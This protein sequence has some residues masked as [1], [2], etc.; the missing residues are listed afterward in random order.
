MLNSRC[1]GNSDRKYQN[2]VT[3][4]SEIYDRIGSHTIDTQ[5]N[6][7]SRGKVQNAVTNS[8][9]SNV[10]LSGGWGI[11]TYISSCYWEFEFYLKQRLIYS[12][13][14]LHTWFH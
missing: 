3:N 13:S 9:E 1:V 8:R 5:S 10:T 6:E 11:W 4:S 14:L 2:V 12:H 7:N